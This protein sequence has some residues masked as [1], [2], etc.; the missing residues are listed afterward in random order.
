MIF[1]VMYSI[2]ERGLL[3][4]SQYYPATDNPY[5]FKISLLLNAPGAFILGLIIGA[6]EVLY[7]EKILDRYPLWIKLVIKTLIYVTLIFIFLVVLSFFANAA[8][9][10]RSPFDPVVVKYVGQFIGAFAFWSIMIYGAFNIMVALYYTETQNGLGQKMF[11]NFFLGKYHRPVQE[12]RIFMFLDMRSSTSIAERLG[13][14]KYYKLLNDYYNNMTDAIIDT[15]GEIYQY[16]G[17]ELIIT[18]EE[19][20]GI[21][22]NTCIRCFE[23]IK[24]AFQ[25]RSDYFIDKFGL[26]PQF[27][28]GIHTG[29]V[30]TGE[31]GTL[32]KEIVYTGDVLNTAA[33]IQGLCNE[34]KADLLVSEPL[35]NLLNLRE[36]SNKCIGEL[37]LK[38]KEKKMGVVRVSV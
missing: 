6:I 35:F 18:W 13:H 4:A 24:Q 33:R 22:D 23:K 36:V 38:G 11:A 17:D 37:S 3:G 2:V 30:T 16:V 34:Y 28:A 12:R 25:D 14:V 32:K 20:E 26:L 9:L 10:D 21:K 19:N 29:Q 15:N 7:F 27:K 5:D 31:I 1:G 8:R